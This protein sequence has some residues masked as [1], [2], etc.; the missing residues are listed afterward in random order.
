MKISVYRLS[1]VTLFRGRM[2]VL[3]PCY[4]GVI[5]ITYLITGGIIGVIRGVGIPPDYRVTRLSS[6]GPKVAV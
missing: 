3:G 1:C 5:G 4:T 6:K 2:E